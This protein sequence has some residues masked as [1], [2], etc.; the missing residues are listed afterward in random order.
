MD[1]TELDAQISKLK[2]EKLKLEKEK[3][4]KEQDEAVKLFDPYTDRIW[5]KFLENIDDFD[6]E[7]E[8]EYGEFIVREVESL[9]DC[10]SDRIYGK[11]MD[12]AKD[13]GFELPNSDEIKKCD[14]GAEIMN[15]D[16]SVC[17]NCWKKGKR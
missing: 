14:C 7:N 9:I 5:Q 3:K 16:H 1:L 17:Y 4:V 10:I 15:P 11:L 6:V 12:Y 8:G 2:E 13:I